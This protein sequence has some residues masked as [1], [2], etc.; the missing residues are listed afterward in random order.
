LFCNTVAV[1]LL[2]GRFRMALSRWQSGALKKREFLVLIIN[3][4]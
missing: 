4:T 3:I 2:H 1:S